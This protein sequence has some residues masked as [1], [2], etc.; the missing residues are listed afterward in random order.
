MVPLIPAQVG[1]SENTIRG[2]SR[3]IEWTSS[4]LYFQHPGRSCHGAESRVERDGAEVEWEELGV[5]V[6]FV[7]A[8]PGSGDSPLAA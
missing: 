5:D 8:V 3:W 1:S 2:L 4:S 6:T 7:V